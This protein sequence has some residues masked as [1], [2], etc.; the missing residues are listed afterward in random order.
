MQNRPLDVEIIVIGD[1]AG[2]R[3]SICDCV[4]GGLL[5]RFQHPR[6]PRPLH[7]LCGRQTGPTALLLRLV[8]TRSSRF[9]PAWAA[10]GGFG[11]SWAFPACSGL[12]HPLEGCGGL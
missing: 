8:S 4:S 1:P 10:L 2:D 11:P 12:P 5:A 3:G 7:H 6:R 9:I